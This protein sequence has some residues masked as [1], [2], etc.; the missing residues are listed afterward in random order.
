M[1]TETLSVLL[2]KDATIIQFD[3]RAGITGY[4]SESVLG[5]NWFDIF[6]HNIDK[7]EV[8]EVFSSFFADL[9]APHWSYDN[10]IECKDGTKKL[11]NFKNRTIQNKDKKTEFIFC[12]AKEA[13]YAFLSAEHI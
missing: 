13:S 6:I 8:L 4:S 3:D 1:N 5:K 10:C 12:T 2:D 7:R 11:L 9:H